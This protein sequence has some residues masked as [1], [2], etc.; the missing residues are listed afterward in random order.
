MNTDAIWWKL[1]LAGSALL[2]L[3]WVVVAACRGALDVPYDDEWE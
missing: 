1:T 2:L 3:V